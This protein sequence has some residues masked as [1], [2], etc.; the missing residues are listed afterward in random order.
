MRVFVDEMITEIDDLCFN[1]A[2]HEQILRMN[3]GDY[4]QLEKPV[5]GKVAN[6]E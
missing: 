3:C 2:S 4:L 6:K 5:V 1:A